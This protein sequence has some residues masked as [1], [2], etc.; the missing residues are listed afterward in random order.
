MKYLTLYCLYTFYL[1]QNLGIETRGRSQNLFT[2]RIPD[3]NSIITYSNFVYLSPSGFQLF[4]FN[5]SVYHDRDNDGR[6]NI[7]SRVPKMQYPG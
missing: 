6:R 1:E 2:A 7:L 4:E 5:N 3:F